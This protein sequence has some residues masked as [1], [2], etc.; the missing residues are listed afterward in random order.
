MRNGAAYLIKDCGD[1]WFYIESGDVRGFVLSDKFSA[2][3]VTVCHKTVNTFTYLALKDKIGKHAAAKAAVHTTYETPD[4]SESEPLVAPMY[5]DAFAYSRATVTDPVVD[6]H[7]GIA[8]ADIEILD[9]MENGDV[10]GTLKSGGLLQVLEENDGWLFVESRDVRGFVARDSVRFGDE[11][12]AEVEEKS[13]GVYAKADE[14]MDPSDNKALY[15]TMKSAKQGSS[16]SEIRKQILEMAASCIGNPYVW[17]GTSLTNGADC[18]GFAQTIYR[19]FGI[20]LPRVACDQAEAGMQIP[21]SQAQPGDLV[22]FA[23]NGYVYH[24]A[25]YAGDNSTVEAYSSSTG[26]VSLS[27]LNERSNLVWACNYLD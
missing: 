14:T 17:G 11:V 24:V 26:I 10:V 12:D 19:S 20:S 3:P 23:K 18:S 13:E 22:F 4:I 15:Y 21:V 6:G 2:E 27:N 1:G 5:N 16:K 25:I 8:N 9:D 7:Y